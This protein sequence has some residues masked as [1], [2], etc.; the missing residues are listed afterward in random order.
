[1]ATVIVPISPMKCGGRMQHPAQIDGCSI[2]IQ[3]QGRRRSH[4]VESGTLSLHRQTLTQSEG[5]D[6]SGRVFSDEERKSLV[7]IVKG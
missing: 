3:R 5:V 4:G 1:M 7:S 6:E 2:V